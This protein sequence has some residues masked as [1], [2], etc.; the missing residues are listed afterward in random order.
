MGAVYP[1]PKMCGAMESLPRF[2]GYGGAQAAMDGA[3]CG[4]REGVYR[5]RAVWVK[6]YQDI[7]SVNTKNPN[8]LFQLCSPRD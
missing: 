5:S 8:Y 4:F 6:R 3:L 1:L 7:P 2:I